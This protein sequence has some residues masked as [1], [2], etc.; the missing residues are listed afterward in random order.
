MTRK[1]R[2]WG[3]QGEMTVVCEKAGVLLEK[4]SHGVTWHGA[5]GYL[6]TGQARLRPVFLYTAV[7]ASSSWCKCIRFGSKNYLYVEWGVFGSVYLVLQFHW[8]KLSVGFSLSNHS[9]SHQ[10]LYDL[11]N[12]AGYAGLRCICI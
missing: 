1:S 6:R 3:K 9:R 8:H 7:P 5:E 11:N 10:C 2:F 12:L 4:G